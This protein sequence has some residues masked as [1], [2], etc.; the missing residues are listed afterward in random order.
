MSEVYACQS[1][2]NLLS[3]AMRLKDEG[4]LADS[5]QAEGVVNAFGG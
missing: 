2:S 1:K 4:V 5:R 3:F